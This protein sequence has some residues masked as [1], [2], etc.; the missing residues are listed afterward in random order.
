MKKKV[1]L[2]LHGFN[3]ASLDLDGHLLIAKEKLQV[4]Q[5]FCLQKDILFCT[6]NV[7]YRN[8]QGIV[9]D[10][11][12]QWKHFL[13]LNFDVVFMGSS[14]GGFSSEYLA[15]KTGCSAIMINPVLKP[16]EL[17]PQFI[18]VNENFE[19]GQPYHW[20]Q[21]HCDQYLFYERELENNLQKINRMI[22]LDRADELLNAEK[23]RIKYQHSSDVICF[24]GGSHG[25]EHM[26]EALPSIEQVLFSHEFND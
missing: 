14:M 13:D 24:D 18:G 17:L 20:E 16:S 15:M 19:T 21:K 2:Y 4:M 8:F 23:T 3:S 5:E 12:L 25:F 6:P 1:I 26:R 9:E 10:M 22:L 11:L 7:D